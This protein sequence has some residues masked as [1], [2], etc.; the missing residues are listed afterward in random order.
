MTHCGICNAKT[1]HLNEITLDGIEDIYNL[2]VCDRCYD[3]YSRDYFSPEEIDNLLKV[4][5]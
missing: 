3:F 2:E 4:G 1:E 5:N